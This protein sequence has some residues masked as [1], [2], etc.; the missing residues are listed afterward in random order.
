MAAVTHN[1]ATESKLSWPTIY[2]SHTVDR[3]VY[4]SRWRVIV[5]MSSSSSRL[6]PGRLL[7][8]TIWYQLS[9]RLCFWPM[10]RIE[11]LHWVKIQNYWK[12]SALTT[13]IVHLISYHITSITTVDGFCIGNKLHRSR[14]C[15][16]DLNSGWTG[17]WQIADRYSK[18]EGF[19]L[20]S[21]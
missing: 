10:A 4:P 9:L 1:P 17:P 5:T 12:S 18:R 15:L 13:P 19:P 21:F 8:S 2:F 20:H 7:T 11:A 6:L 3:V 16:T 14:K